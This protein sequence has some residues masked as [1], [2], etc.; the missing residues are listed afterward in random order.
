METF[1]AFILGLVQGIT[2][3]L[4]IS[5]SAHLVLVP[6]FFKWSDPGLEV[7]VF[8][9]LGTLA[10]VILYFFKDWWLLV[11][12][13][14]ASIIERRIGFD[15]YRLL[16]WL[17][18]V[19]TI[20]GV[21]AGLLLEK[22][23]ES[24][25]RQP[26]IIATTLAGVGFLI[27]WVDGK[28]TA[29]RTLDELRMKDALLIGFAQAFAIIPGVSRSGSTMTM[30]RLLGMNREAAAR[31][32][33]LMSV[34]ITSGAVIWEFRKL[35]KPEMASTLAQVPHS[36]LITGCLSSLVF[37]LIAIHFLLQYL[38]NADFRVFAWYR[39]ALGIFIVAY[40]LF[41]GKPIT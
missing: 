9:H 33:F 19:A 4:P 34:P 18:V 11:K 40:S 32:S 36:Y 25:F 12:G 1:H 31:F 8:I 2:E 35:F 5:S 13:G 21:C 23:A 6:W 3:F 38:K 17:I 16:F 29:L 20:P 41:I 24:T 28:Y 27:Y 10:A 37:G 39:L 22:Y 7:D 30:A 26:L 15:R 14:I